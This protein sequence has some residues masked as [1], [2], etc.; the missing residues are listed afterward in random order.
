MISIIKTKTLYNHL[1]NARS[2][3][4]D[5]CT[6]LKVD[7]SFEN[8]LYRVIIS[9]RTTILTTTKEL[10]LKDNQPKNQKTKT[11]NEKKKHEHLTSK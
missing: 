8:K 3:F 7:V 10:Q 1:G 6:L 2:K 5:Y 9:S 11:K 4:A